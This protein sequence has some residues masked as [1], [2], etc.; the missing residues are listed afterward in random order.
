MEPDVQCA[1]SITRRNALHVFARRMWVGYC[2]G[3]FVALP[4]LKLQR[5]KVPSD[6]I[7]NEESRGRHSPPL[8]AIDRTGA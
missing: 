1:K 3:R 5:P 4:S 6:L 8:G 2:S 7:F